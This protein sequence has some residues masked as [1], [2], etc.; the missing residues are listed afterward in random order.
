MQLG[1]SLWVYVH[2]DELTCINSAQLVTR[3]NEFPAE[4]MMD[5]LLGTG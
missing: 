3:T 5:S 1:N 2:E 4:H